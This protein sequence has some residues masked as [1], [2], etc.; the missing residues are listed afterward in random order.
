[1]S[2]KAHIFGALMLLGATVAAYGNSAQPTHVTESDVAEGMRGKG[3][4]VRAEQISM[5]ATI[6]A[7]AEH[8]VLEAL[9]IEPLS[10]DTSRVLMRC[11]NRN[12]CIPFYAVVNGL[13]PGQKFS[14]E[15]PAAREASLEKPALSPV[16]MK[17]G[18]TATLEIV[19]SE[20]LI[21]IPVVCLENGRQGERIRV[22]S[23]DRNHTYLGEVTS[24]GLLRSRM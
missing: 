5:L 21:T 17:R 15:L 22:S 12:S 18:S 13:T 7:R 14:A 10:G 3:V 4:I 1:M 11:V 20:M 8:P 19:S 6:P 16:V 9:K 24:P 2:T 23:T